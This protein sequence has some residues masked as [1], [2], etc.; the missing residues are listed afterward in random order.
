MSQDR[1]AKQFDFLTEADRLKTVLRATISFEVADDRLYAIKGLG[2]NG[3]V[4]LG[5]FEFA[6]KTEIGVALIWRQ[7]AENTVRSSAFDLF[8]DRHVVVAM[9]R[10]IADIDLDEVVDQQHLDDAFYPDGA[11]GM[12][13]KD[14]GIERDVPAVLT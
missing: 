6:P 2:E 4:G 14:Q 12:F 10:I 3:V 1:L 13:C 11:V 9:D 8:D 5:R 7:E